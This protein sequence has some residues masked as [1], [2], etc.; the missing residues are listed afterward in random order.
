MIR[1]KILCAYL[2]LSPL[3]LNNL[4]KKKKIFIS[5]HVSYCK[6]TVEEN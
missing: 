3:I 5:Y 2:N 6:S 1:K 4:N